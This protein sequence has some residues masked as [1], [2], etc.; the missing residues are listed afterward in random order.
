MA[1]TMARTSE[2]DTDIQEKLMHTGKRQQIIKSSLAADRVS[3]VAL[4]F[5]Q[6]YCEFM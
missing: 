6:A 3:L 2:S 5:G 4:I 1:M